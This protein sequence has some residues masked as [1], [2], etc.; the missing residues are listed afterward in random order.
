MIRKDKFCRARKS[1]EKNVK[2]VK[3]AEEVEGY[4]GDKDFNILLKVSFQ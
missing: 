3:K 4:E 2:A 1:G